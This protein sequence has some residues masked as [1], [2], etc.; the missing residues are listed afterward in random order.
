MLTNL[1][2]IFFLVIICQPG[3][4]HADTYVITDDTPIYFTVDEGALDVAS[5]PSAHTQRTLTIDNAYF[6]SILEADPPAPYTRYLLATKIKNSSDFSRKISLANA[7]WMEDVKLKVIY[8]NG[9]TQTFELPISFHNKLS[10]SDPRRIAPNKVPSLYKSFL[11]APNKTVDLIVE[12]TTKAATIRSNSFS[13]DFYHVDEYVEHRRLGLWLEGILVGALLALTVF[14]WY[15]FY[16][17]RD[18]T[19][20][21]YGL[22]ILAAVSAVLTQSYHDGSR[23]FEFVFD[24]EKKS[25][26]QQQS[27]GTG[28][29]I[30]CSYLQAMVYVIF[31]RSFLEVKKYF[32][33]IY[34]ITN[35]YLL[36]YMF[37]MITHIFLRHELPKDIYLFP[38]FASTFAILLLI[39]YA[40]FKRMM[41]GLEI[42]K[43]FMI[44]MFP[45]LFFRMVFLFG[46]L[47]LPNPFTLLPDS[48]V[49][50]F[51]DSGSVA[52]ALG[53]VLEAMI[54]ALAVIARTRWLQEQ[55]ATNI[56]SQ[57]ALVENQNKV[58]EATVAERTQELE[59]QHKELD[60]AHQIVVGS[61]NYASR[62]QKG[63]LPRS[64]R[65]EGRFASFDSIWEPRDTIGGDLWWVSSTQNSGPY[66]LAVADCTGHGVPGAILS[67]L[68]SNSLE[69]I[70]ANNGDENPADALVSLDYLVRTGLNQDSADSESDDGCDAAIIRIRRDDKILEY[71]GAKIDLYHL[72]SDGT[73]KRYE[74]SR[75]SLGYKE[76]LNTV[77]P[78][79][80]IEYKSGDGFVIVTDGFTDQIGGYGKISHSY[81]YKRLIKTLE[82]INSTDASKI[83][84]ML[85]A[86]LKAWQGNQKRR[87]DV[88]VV[89]FSLT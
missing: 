87:D 88:T 66:V 89:C 3:F 49:R 8:E 19:S 80:K 81:G 41:A 48:G 54:M 29:L 65:L 31:A 45:Y 78:L 32:P 20:F 60:E 53:L 47:G 2:R 38:L 11:I 9:E 72:K 67:L 30:V 50:T 58:L 56:K 15:S 62:L 46:F 44:A 34:L 42:A 74:P 33:K 51:L 10:G 63:Q 27:M 71:A 25:I 85:A 26:N 4:I 13:L 28:L 24:I 17:S 7:R 5:Q 75:V 61:L 40:A 55:L 18:T 21:Y 37:H 14:S 86:D 23:L 64:H 70:Y 84:S 69:R 35:I 57:K 59:E 6:Q 39:Y 22:W 77:P 68:V 79:H 82:T 76:K 1:C 12:F 36:W 83:K 73:V 43:F 16:Q 52:Q